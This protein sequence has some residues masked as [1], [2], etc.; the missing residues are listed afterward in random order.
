MKSSASVQRIALLPE[1]VRNQIAAGE[2][3]E[4][5]A[6]VVKELLDNALDAGATQIDVDLDDGGMRSIRVQD[7][8]IGMGREDL[9]LC[10]EPH[11][12]S[13][14]RTPDDLEHI[15][16]LGFRGEALASMGSIARCSVFSREPESDLGLQI[17]NEGG[18]LSEIHEAGGAHG[19]LVT[20][21]DLFFNTPARRRFLKRTST[22]L[23][24]CLDMVQRAALAHVGVGF[25]AT[26]AGKRLYDVTADMDLL[27][28]IRRTFGS[29][30]ADSLMVVEASSGST[31]LFGYVAP[32]RF[33]RR[34]TSRQM[35]F[36][37]GRSLRDKVLTRV[38]K[39]GY[40]GFL[41]E[42]RQPVAFLQLSVDPAVVDVNVHPA[43]SEVRFR[44]QR[45]LFGFLVTA[46]REAVAKT[47]MSTPG[48]SMIRTMERRTVRPG[49]APGQGVLPN[50]G[51][52]V[53]AAR[54]TSEPFQVRNVEGDA[55]VVPT[56]G[57]RA[58]DSGSPGAG[59]GA[60]SAA[61]DWAEVDQLRGPFLQID[62]TYIV[63]ALPQGFEII[64]QHAL[65]E[66]VTYEGLLCEVR[67]GAVE[68]QQR[69]VPE[70]IELSRADVALVSDHL[71]SL[72]QIGVDVAVF[73]ETT[74]AVHGL[75]ARLRNPDIEGL[76]RD[77][78][79]VIRRTGKTPAAEDVLE[80]LL[81]SAACR[82]SIMAGDALTEDE[83][84]VL[85][86]RARELETDQTCPHAR[87]TRVKFDL[88]DLEKAFHRR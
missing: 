73:G 61:T 39:E 56:Q 14:L 34:D 28:R 12:T 7:N 33:S 68:V 80:E 72:K 15:A 25:G 83:I 60:A 37:N 45:A 48:E 66:R 27:G 43:K 50:P 65:H 23:G 52:M 49:D 38:L 13:K 36:L 75:P 63:R 47:D 17:D 51:P 88:S 64:D 59:V 85:L 62:R 5:P 11:A 2:V 42:G 77:V 86:T 32:P 22:E 58:A 16:S 79:E 46:L 44:E 1:V 41:V 57:P 81:H 26:H 74:V 71:D 9:A 6:S 70:L 82:S 24:R 10:F 78:V 35:W 40:R 20:V 19:T 87:P 30:L 4:R 31:R 54:R 69:L 21:R 18:R 29:E 3:I 55:Y 8:G 53:G 84:R 76:V 67:A